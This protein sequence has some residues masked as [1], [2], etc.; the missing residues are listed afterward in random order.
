MEAAHITDIHD[1]RLVLE[2]LGFVGD[3]LLGYASK[4]CVGSSGRIEQHA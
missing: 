1:I 4:A 2:M 3:D